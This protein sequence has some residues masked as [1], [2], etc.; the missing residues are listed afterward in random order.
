MSNEIGKD[1][2]GTTEVSEKASRRRYSAE[3]KSRILD[4]AD[5]CDQPGQLGELLRREGLYSSLL[6]NWRKQRSVGLQPKRRGRKPIPN[7]AE[8]LE[9]QRVKRENSRLAERLR[10]AELI[11]DVQKKVCEMLGILPV[12]QN[13]ENEE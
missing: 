13:N 12:N 2:R 5:R 10:Q 3:Y 6:S 7:Q 9:L 4:E 11:I 8:H 1:G